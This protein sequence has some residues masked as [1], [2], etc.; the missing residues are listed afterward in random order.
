VAYVFAEV[1]GRPPAEVILDVQADERTAGSAIPE[2]AGEGIPLSQR[3]YLRRGAGLPWSLPEGTRAA[4][5]G[6]GEWK[7]TLDAFRDLGIAFGAA[8]V[9]IFFVLWLQTGSVVVTLILMTAIPLT[10]IGIMPGFWLLNSVGAL[11]IAGH[12]NPVFFTATAMIGMIALSGIVVRNS[13]V[14]VEFVH[15]ALREGAELEDALLQSGAI[16][17]RPILLTAGT[18]FLGNIVITLDPIFSGLAWAIIFGILA[19]TVF[20]LG[21]VPV[22]YH[23]VYAN[24]PGHGLPEVSEEGQAS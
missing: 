7:I 21:V 2:G 9:A 22:I 8:N 20:T 12:P 23:L 11:E 16:R 1:A 13:L 15:Q 10:M 17:T 19:S 3:D 6:E 14:L 4:W 18:T 5:T 24:R